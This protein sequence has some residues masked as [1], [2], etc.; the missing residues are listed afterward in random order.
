MAFG[1]TLMKLKL[2]RL[3]TIGLITTGC[4]SYQPP[5]LPMFEPEFVPDPNKPVD[6][7]L[8][9]R[10]TIEPFNL[11]ANDYISCKELTMV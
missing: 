1:V 2:G 5:L 8:E 4:N 10:H 9:E 6:W 7:G 11:T 3:L